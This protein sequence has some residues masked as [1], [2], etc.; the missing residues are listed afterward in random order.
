MGKRIISQRRGR[1][2]STYSAHSHRWNIAISH[3][4]YDD[5]EKNGVLAGTVKDLTHCK[6]HTAPIAII[7]FENGEYHSV[8]API[9]IKV[10]DTVY[11]GEKGKPTVGSTLPLKSIPEGTPI[12]NIEVRIAD[13]GS[14]VR[15]SGSG[16][17]LLNIT[18]KGVVV[19]MPSKKKKTFN[20]ECRAT[21]GRIAGSGKKEKP[22]V[23]AGKHYHMMKARGK[24]YPRTSGVAMNAVD[25]PF[26]SGRGRHAGK[27]LTAPRFAPPGRN[28]GK[29]RARRTGK[30]R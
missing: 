4:K 23:K 3:R 8:F 25:H 29:I 13:G 21:I 22:L 7:Q 20:P 6:G 2:T 12:C 19:Q 9:G 15:T 17:K 14:L 26:G 18:D 11:T 27:P 1:G 10:G 5:I 24:L 30:I 28:V 16:A